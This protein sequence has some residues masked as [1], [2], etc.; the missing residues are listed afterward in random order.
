MFLELNSKASR[1]STGKEKESRCLLFTSPNREI[2]H[3]LVVVVQSDGKE[4]CKNLKRDART[5]MLFCQFKP[6]AFV[7][8]SFSSPSLLLKL[9]ILLNWLLKMFT[10][11]PE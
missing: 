10:T 9:P 5:K 1:Q 6:I 4:M 2:R 8:L 11:E 3:F 7:P